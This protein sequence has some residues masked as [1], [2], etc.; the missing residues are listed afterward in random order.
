MT[1]RI[2]DKLCRVAR[3]A[4]WPGSGWMTHPTPP[5]HLNTTGDK[6][7]D[8]RKIGI[9]RRIYIWLRLT[10]RGSVL[11]RFM[12]RVHPHD[13]T[14]SSPPPE[15]LPE[16]PQSIPAMSAQLPSNNFFLFFEKPTDRTFG[17]GQGVTAY[18][19]DRFFYPNDF[20]GKGFRFWFSSVALLHKF[21]LL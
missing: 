15:I 17:W 3:K 10:G 1:G 18:T 21:L 14:S 13:R 16:T 2:C 12:K 4:T 11:R 7:S 8:S 5:P 19:I 6:T 9:T 20:P